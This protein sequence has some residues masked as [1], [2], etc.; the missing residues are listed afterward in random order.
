[1]LTGPDGALYYSEGG[2]YYDGPI[3]RLT[4]RSSLVFSSVSTVPAVVNAGDRLTYT[5][6]VRNVGTLSTTFAL[7]ATRCRPKPRSRLSTAA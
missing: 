1:M 2:G 5:V 3:K 6:N 4:R 7:T